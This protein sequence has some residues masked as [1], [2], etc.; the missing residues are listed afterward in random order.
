M[1]CIYRSTVRVPSELLR[2]SIDIVISLSLPAQHHTKEKV[3]ERA[4]QLTNMSD[5]DPFKQALFRIIGRAELHKRTVPLVTSTTEDWIW[6]QLAMVIA[7]ARGSPFL[8][9]KRIIG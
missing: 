5:G 9:L 8:C 1:G 3:E 2:E 6:F 7:F 4:M